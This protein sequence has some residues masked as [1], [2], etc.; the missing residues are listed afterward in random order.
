MYLIKNEYFKA[1]HNQMKTKITLLILFITCFGF[2]QN[3]INYKAVIKDDLGN[4]VANDLIVVQF[5]ILQGVAE[6][7]VY[8]E[9]HSPTTDDNGIILVN[10]GEGTPISG[11]FTD[12]DWGSDT[13]FL[14]V[15]L[16]TGS[17]LVDMGTTAFKSVP[18]AMSASTIEL[19]YYGDTTYSG[20][21]FQVHNNDTNAT[22]GIVGTT[23]TDGAAI[24][25]N[26]AGVL[27]YST[28][29]HGVYGVSVNS[30]YAGVQGVSESATGVG[31]QGYAIGGG[32]GG[33]FYTTSFGTAALTTGTGNVGIGIDTP[34][35]KLH[36]GGD[37]FVQS[38]LGEL[39][40]GYPNNGNQWKLATFSGGSDLI[41]RSKPDG[42]N[43]LSTRFN[44]KQ[45]GDIV[46]A[47]T[48]GR[49]GIGLSNPV[50]PFSVLQASG[51]ANTVR[52]E[53]QE[54]PVGKDLLELIVPSGSTSGS[55]FIEMQ[56]GATIV[57]AVNSDGSARFS[58]KLGIDGTPTGKLHIFQNGQTLGSGLRFTDGTANSDWDITH[59]FA[60][61]FHYGAT[62]KGFINAT[63]GVYTVSSDVNLKSNIQNLD[64]TLDLVKQLR[65]TTYYYKDDTSKTKAI[66]LIAQEVKPIFPELVHFSEADG[67]YG[68]DYAGFSVVTIKAI[69]DQQTIIESQQKQIDE[70]KILVQTLLEK[71]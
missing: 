49:V 26:R 12:I 63:T 56:N 55:Q 58:S 30:F 31:I 32:V 42:S 54:H 65:P 25:A 29:A 69:Q 27:G 9:T 39:V 20:A 36:V 5:S 46:M 34:E 14:N 67:L 7:N 60:L 59:G 19:P 16:N 17:G 38:N 35:M 10:I 3:G 50:N 23:G 41:F 33:H 48:A 62:L 71:Q 8:S 44:L 64:S 2:A 24:P 40:I 1:K 11:I 66:G 53:S 51:T 61:R 21:A 52:I 13:H 37:L 43:T 15:Q 45:N 70:L 68:I 18:Y 57:A 28:N 6:T 22:Y 47:E 4:V